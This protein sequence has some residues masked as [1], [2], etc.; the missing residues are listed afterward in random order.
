MRQGLIHLALHRV[1]GPAQSVA[2]IDVGTANLSLLRLQVRQPRDST[3]E[4]A[5][6]S[7]A[8]IAAEALSAVAALADNKGSVAP[9]AYQHH[10]EAVVALRA[11]GHPPTPSSWPRTPQWAIPDALL[12][13]SA[14]GVGSLEGPGSDPGPSTFVTP[15]SYRMAQQR[16]DFQPVAGNHEAAVQTRRVSG[17]SR[18]YR[19]SYADL[20]DR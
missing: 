3:L 9:G 18:A 17:A 12:R 5:P 2:S 1:V 6:S 19:G 10:A 11:H 20:G 8:S 13:L 7:D 15:R 16:A 14:L 4:L